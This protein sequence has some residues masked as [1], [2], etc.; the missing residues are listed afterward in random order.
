[1]IRTVLLA[2][3]AALFAVS[4]PITPPVAQAE[5]VKA[6]CAVTWTDGSRGRETGSCDFRQSGGYVL[7]VFQGGKP[8]SEPGGY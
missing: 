3:A 7:Q 1:M 2:S 8:A 6:W 5:I 4:E